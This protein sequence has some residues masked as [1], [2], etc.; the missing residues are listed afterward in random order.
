MARN[1]NGIR[2]RELARRKSERLRFRGRVERFGSKSAF[3]GDDLKTILLT[4]VAFADTGAPATDHMWFTAGKWTQGAK[5]GD[6]IEFDGRIERYVKGYGGQNPLYGEVS[7]K[8][9][10]TDYRITRPTNVAILG[11]RKTADAP[12]ACI[13]RALRN[14]G[15]RGATCPCPDCSAAWL[16]QEL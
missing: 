8:P 11:V 1:R 10:E 5:A 13:A 9:L 3:K 16:E 7:D 12:K 15:Y 4:D 6:T 2:R 14:G